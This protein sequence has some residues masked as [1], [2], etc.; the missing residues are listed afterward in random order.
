MP[1]RPALTRVALGKMAPLS[2]SA[3]AL[4]SA[5]MLMPALRDLSQ[6][7]VPDTVDALRLATSGAALA[8][9]MPARLAPLLLAQEVDEMDTGLRLT[10]D[11]L[12][13][14]TGVLVV[15][16]VLTFVYSAFKDW[17]LE[18]NLKNFQETKP[19]VMSE[20]ER[21]LSAEDGNRYTRRLVAKQ[22]GK[23]KRK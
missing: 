10:A 21:E 1:R 22:Q 14:I 13:L 5:P 17:Q 8:P 4:P 3:A 11:V 6:F 12:V 16:L 15:A 19:D 2:L 23:R 9:A 20:I 7:A 18:Q